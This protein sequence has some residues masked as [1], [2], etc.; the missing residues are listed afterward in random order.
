MW[1]DW[2]KEMESGP[3]TVTTIEKNPKSS[4]QLKDSVSKDFA[5]HV[6]CL[7]Q[8][9]FDP[10]IYN[11]MILNDFRANFENIRSGRLRMIVEMAQS[12]FTPGTRNGKRA[13]CRCN[14]GIC[15]S[16][17]LFQRRCMYSHFEQTHR[18]SLRGQPKC[19][20]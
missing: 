9:H 14:R 10:C 15:M 12:E 17:D 20:R 11:P 13:K 5:A 6:S 7:S 19:R 16:M 1:E 8:P 18:T 4:S 3:S 2:C